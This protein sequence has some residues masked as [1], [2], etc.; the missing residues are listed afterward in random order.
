MAQF[1]NGGLLRTSVNNPF[2]VFKAQYYFSLC[3][4]GSPLRPDLRG[5]SRDLHTFTVA[6]FLNGGLLRTLVNNPFLVFKNWLK[7]VF[8]IFLH[9]NGP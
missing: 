6:Q 3:T 9:L 5:P 7:D 1:L 8:I 2:F 4:G